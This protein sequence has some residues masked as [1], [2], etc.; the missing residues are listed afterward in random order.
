MVTCKHICA[1][2]QLP[3]QLLQ[4]NLFIKHEYKH[5]VAVSEQLIKIRLFDRKEYVC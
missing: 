4:V 3:K 5:V 1:N 2:M